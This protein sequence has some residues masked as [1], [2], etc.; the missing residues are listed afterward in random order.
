MAVVLAPQASYSCTPITR[1]AH[2]ARGIALQVDARSLE[3]L[4]EDLGSV[5][6]NHGF[7]SVMHTVLG[8]GE[9]IRFCDAVENP[10]YNGRQDDY[11][12]PINCTWGFHR[13]PLLPESLLSKT[14]CPKTAEEMIALRLTPPKREWNWQPGSTR[15]EAWS[16]RDR[17]GY[18]YRNY[19]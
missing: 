18:L 1:S 9:Q 15:H 10:R 6:A 16:T 3:L 8:I 4:C 5:S 2:P 14:T 17:A 12:N 13:P 11:N 7:N 19:M